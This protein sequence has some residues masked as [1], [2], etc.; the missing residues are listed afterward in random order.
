MNWIVGLL[1]CLI[2]C[3]HIDSNQQNLDDCSHLSTSFDNAI[4]CNIIYVTQGIISSKIKAI[5]MIRQCQE[6]TLRNSLK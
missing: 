6:F 2:S 3:P 5:I 4:H 1:T